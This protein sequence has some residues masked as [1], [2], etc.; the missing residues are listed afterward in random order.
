MRTALINTEKWSQTG[1]EEERRIESF[2]EQDGNCCQ[3][4]V[5]IKDEF[6]KD[7]FNIERRGFT[8]EDNPQ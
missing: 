7:Q 8:K 1:F 5:I 2:I 3:K 6:V 4:R